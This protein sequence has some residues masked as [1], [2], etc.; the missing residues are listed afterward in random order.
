M[1]MSTHIVGFRP[2]DETWSKMKAVWD[3]CTKAGVAIPRDVLMFFDGE[4]PRDDGVRV[5]INEGWV[6]ICLYDGREG[7]DLDITKLPAGVTR[8]RFLSS[9]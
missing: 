5:E 7:F 1:G 3:A 9:W 6:Q 2:A 8:V 4:A